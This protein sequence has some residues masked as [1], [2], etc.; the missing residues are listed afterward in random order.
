MSSTPPDHSTADN[1]TASVGI[2]DPDTSGTAGASLN[3]SV[4]VPVFN[5]ADGIA[6]LLAE[7]DACLEGRT[8][9]EVVIVDDCSTDDTA[10]RVRGYRRD[11][12]GLRLRLV[13]HRSNAGQSRAIRTGVEAARGRLIATIDGDGQN[14]PADIPRLEEAAMAAPDGR[15]LIVCGHRVDRHDDLSRRLASRIA[16]RVRAAVLRD[17]TP[18]TGCGLKVLPRALFLELP[19]FDHMHRFLPALVRQAGGHSLS[20]PVGH[21][22]RT[23]GVSKYGINDRLWAGIVDLLGVS[24]LGR[25][26]RAVTSEE[27]VD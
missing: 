1:S 21:R 4:V 22:P 19:Y 8:D 18:D 13:R 23:H 7:I 27:I 5:E 3:L 10:E 26:R 9:A 17:E 14:D 24:W 16:N 25:R 20:V 12:R 6:A 2:D 11:A 15:G